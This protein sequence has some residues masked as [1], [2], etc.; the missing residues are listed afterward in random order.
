MDGR[1]HNIKGEMSN[2]KVKGQW[3]LATIDIFILTFSPNCHYGNAIQYKKDM[4]EE[5]CNKK[6]SSQNGLI[7][8]WSV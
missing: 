8:F 1:F 6:S 7:P 5:A 2:C 3:N 4:I